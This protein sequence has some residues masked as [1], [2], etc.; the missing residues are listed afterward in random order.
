MPQLM[1]MVLSIC[2]PNQK[3]Q[4]NCQFPDGKE[5]QRDPRHNVLVSGQDDGYKT[6]REVGEAGNDQQN[7][8]DFG[9]EARFDYEDAK[10]KE[11]QTPECRDN[12]NSIAAQTE[13]A[14]REGIQ[15]GFGECR[16]EVR[17]A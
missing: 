9:E 17:A 10:W 1:S 8:Q 3:P 5:W 15:L 6:T 7:A 13:E 14:Q 12:K 2:T 11:P 16:Q 4:D